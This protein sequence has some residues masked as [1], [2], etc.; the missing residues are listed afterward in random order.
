MSDSMDALRAGVDWGDRSHAV[1][2]LD[3]NGKEVMSFRVPHTAE[4][5]VQ[6]VNR[7][8]QCGPIS[9]VAVEKARNLVVQ[10]LL[11]GGFVVFPVNPKLSHAW[12]QGWKMSAP[13]SDPTDAWVLAEGLRQHQDQL[14]S[15]RP[16]DPQTRELAM[17]CADESRL[18]GERTALVNRLQATLKEYYPS[19]LEWFSDWAA[20]SAWDFVLTFDRPQMLLRASPKKLYGFLKSHHIGLSPIWQERVRRRNASTPWPSDPATVEAKAFLAVALAKQLRTLQASLQAY[21]ERIEQ[22]YHD[23][24]DASLFSSLPGAGP[25]LGPRLL[26]HFGADRERYE[27]AESLQELSGTVPVTEQSGRYRRVRLRRACQK[28]FRDTMHLFALQTIKRS[29]WSRAFYDRARRAGQ[30]H[31]LALRNLAA[32]WLEILYRMWKDRTCYDESL[33]LASLIRRRSPLVQEIASSC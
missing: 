2:V 18:I 8:R 27:S 17:L 3:Q 7:L 5:L 22:L 1:C 10:K 24:P 25:K 14:R 4:G 19:A 32:K 6:M 28:P 23:H 11:E 20:P 21:R 15:L 9:G 16:G 30:S 13:K 31:A 33:H 12:R 26:S 29:V